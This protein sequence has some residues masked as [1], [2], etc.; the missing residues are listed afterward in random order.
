MAAPVDSGAPPV[1]SPRQEETF[2]IPK[3]LE[4]FL[5]TKNNAALP[6]L[7][8]LEKCCNG[9]G[10]FIDFG[11][12]LDEALKEKMMAVAF[13]NLGI[14]PEQRV[15][16][17]QDEGLKS[18]T[19]QM[20]E[21]LFY[22]LE[23]M[24]LIPDLDHHENF[25]AYAVSFF[26]MNSSSAQEFLSGL[27]KYPPEKLASLLRN[28]F[29]INQHMQMSTRH[30][31]LYTQ[32]THAA[33][34][35]D[36]IEAL[37][38]IPD[39]EQAKITSLTSRFFNSS[40]I[41]S[42]VA[43]LVKAVFA[44][45]T[46]RRKEIV[47]LVANS[48]S[49]FW[50]ENRCRLLKMLITLPSD[51]AAE[52]MKMANDYY[53][54]YNIDGNGCK[55]TAFV[56][57]LIQIPRELRKEY[58]HYVGQC[59]S[60]INDFQKL[61]EFYDWMSTLL[62]VEAVALL[63]KIYSVSTRMAYPQLD[64]QY[65]QT[66]SDAYVIFFKCLKDLSQDEIDQILS[67]IDT[68]NKTAKYLSHYFRVMSLLPI[69]DRQTTE[70]QADRF[71]GIFSI[72]KSLECLRTTVPDQ[73]ASLLR[74]AFRLISDRLAEHGQEHLVF[75]AFKPL[76]TREQIAENAMWLISEARS[77]PPITDLVQAVSQLEDPKYIRSI[78]PKLKITLNVFPL[79]I[80]LGKIPKAQLEIMLPALKSLKTEE[81]MQFFI[82]CLAE[83]P[84]ESRLQYQDK[85]LHACS[86]SN[87]EML[88]IRHFVQKAP[89]SQK[90]SIFETTVVMTLEDLENYLRKSTVAMDL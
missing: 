53:N 30:N 77:M 55:R 90:I 63:K 74:A 70:Y 2:T 14:P 7:V 35:L 65:K 34:C 3:E 24:N 22:S 42:E 81:Q 71:C 85:L 48:G 73:R 32:R 69:G 4:V 6:S 39:A 66:D 86:K 19:N 61:A 9:F 16:E 54:G 28:L 49:E 88:L 59:S 38:K 15:M 75:E 8:Y 76:P 29:V 41:G 52:L 10:H 87:N 37:N 57:A 82:G 11:H 18:R 23:L 26:M 50:T 78:M 12:L 5:R 13:R 1:N 17:I 62:Q 80:N 45:Q 60:N 27:K 31:Q 83:F 79:I 72:E 20:T 89:P 67:K 25:T 46:E 58:Q 84:E 33:E 56:A 44:L 40:L 21:A 64:F 36:F 43:L 68:K 47:T 51:E